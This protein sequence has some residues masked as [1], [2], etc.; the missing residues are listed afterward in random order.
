M[1]GRG[2]RHSK[3]EVDGI[4]H[5]IDNKTETSSNRRK[6]GAAI[7]SL[8]LT[9]ESRIR[10]GGMES[11]AADIHIFLLAGF[12]NDG[13]SPLLC[14]WS[15]IVVAP[16]VTCQEN[17]QGWMRRAVWKKLQ[18]EDAAEIQHA[19]CLIASCSLVSIKK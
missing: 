8:L 3:E 19:I 11:L 9:K 1:G 4:L 14:L 5:E 17:C 18:S 7:V 15:L 12:R 10:T 6:P 13:A 2:F 16:L